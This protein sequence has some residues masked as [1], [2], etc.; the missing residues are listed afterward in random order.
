MAALFCNHLRA[1]GVDVKV[2][3]EKW[4][5]TQ[6]EIA[7]LMGTNR[8]TIA[9]WLGKGKDDA[10]RSGSTSAQLTLDFWDVVLSAWLE[11]DRRY[12]EQYQAFLAAKNRGKGRA[13]RQ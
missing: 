10:G 8:S 3:K 4:G 6:D 1:I 9:H 12:P 5:L 2:F 7:V 13:Y 11:S